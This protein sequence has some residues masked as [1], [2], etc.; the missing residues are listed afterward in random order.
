MIA[1]ALMLVTRQRRYAAVMIGALSWQWVLPIALQDNSVKSSLGDLHRYAVL[2]NLL[3]FC[4]LAVGALVLMSTML[5]GDKSAPLFIRIIG[6]A[7]L[8]ALAIPVTMGIAFGTI[9]GIGSSI[10][11]ANGWVYHIGLVSGLMLAAFIIVAPHGA[12][13][14]YYAYGW[15]A[16][17]LELAIYAADHDATGQSKTEFWLLF[18]LLLGVTVAVL[19]PRW[20][21]Q[22]PKP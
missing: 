10:E 8:I 16:A 13:A 1:A 12:T 5:R 17:G 11:T 7:A 22:R 4:A 18:V 15:L 19:V 6:G 14:R 2:G 20:P 9:Q 3:S 21:V